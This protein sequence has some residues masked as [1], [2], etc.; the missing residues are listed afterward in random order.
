MKIHSPV[1]ER[2]DVCDSQ[3]SAPFCLHD[4]HHVL[5]FAAP[6]FSI[7]STTVSSKPHHTSSFTTYV[8]EICKNTFAEA[9]RIVHLSKSPLHPE[10]T[11]ESCATLSC[12]FFISCTLFSWRKPEGMVGS[13]EGALPLEGCQQC[14]LLVLIWQLLKLLWEYHF[15]SLRLFPP[16]K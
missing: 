16:N 9:V 3:S 13:T 5:L 11:H 8:R 2:L 15:I 14:W 4:I 12:H 1:D 6:L 7:R 10:P